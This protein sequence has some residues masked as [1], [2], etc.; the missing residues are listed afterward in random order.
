MREIKF[1]AYRKDDN[2]MLNWNDICEWEV[3]F[4]VTLIDHLNDDNFIV[5]QYTGLK[6]KNGVEIYESDII[7][8]VGYKEFIEL[9]EYRGTAFT[10]Q[11]D[12]LSDFVSLCNFNVEVIGNI[13]TNPE[14]LEVHT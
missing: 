12:V 13:Y 4:G 14:L 1:R 3:Q 8:A 7:K 5:L 10:A 6:D 9:V 2:T 11:G